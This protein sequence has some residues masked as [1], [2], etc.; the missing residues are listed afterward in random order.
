MSQT[1]ID[2]DAS[3]AG[4]QEGKEWIA[5]VEYLKNMDDTDGDGIPD[6]DDFYRKPPLRL[7]PVMNDERR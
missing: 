2:F 5:L 6:M 7:K 4:I 3:A 1:L